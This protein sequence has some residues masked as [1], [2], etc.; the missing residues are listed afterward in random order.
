MYTKRGLLFERVG[1]KAEFVYQMKSGAWQTGLEPSD[2]RS[3]LRSLFEIL[4]E[5]FKLRKNREK[6]TFWLSNWNS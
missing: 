4:F 2:L 1:E 5:T 6:G 3:R